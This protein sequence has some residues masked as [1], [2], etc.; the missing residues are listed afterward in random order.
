MTP[1]LEATTLPDH[2]LTV[3]IDRL[4]GAGLRVAAHEMDSGER[5]HM[6]P[7]AARRLARELDESE[8]G[9]ALAPVAVALRH[10]AQRLETAL[11]EPLGPA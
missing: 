1:L 5:R 3:G 10:A 9:P 7:A 8:E 11:S 6:S 2:G 4:P